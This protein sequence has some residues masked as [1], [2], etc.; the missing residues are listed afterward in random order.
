MKKIISLLI[1][2]ICMQYSKANNVE[3]NNISLVNNGD[4]GYVQFDLKWDNSWR[5]NTAQANYDGVWVF[6]KFKT[7]TGNWEQLPINSVVTGQNSL[8]PSG[9]AITQPKSYPIGSFQ[10]ISGRGF[11]VHRSA[12]NIGT[13]NLNITGMRIPLYTD[14][15]PSNIDLRAYAI[16]MVYIPPKYLQY[17]IGDG[18]GTNES[19]FAIHAA[20]TKNYVNAGGNQTVTPPSLNV[21]ANFFDDAAIEAPNTFTVGGSFVNSTTDINDGISVTGYINPYF[22]AFG[23]MW[24][25][26]Y[27][28]TQGAYRDFLNTL[29]LTQQTNR[30]AN[31]PTSTIGTGALTTSGFSRN[32]LEISIPSTAG[33][34]ATYGCDA[35]GNNVY[36]EITDGEFVACNYMNWPDIAA[37]L[38]WSGL[39]PMTEI[40]YERI[41][42]GQTGANTVP[43]LGEFAWGTTSIE[44]IAPVIANAYS[45]N[46]IITNSSSTLGNAIYGNALTGPTRNGIFATATSTRITSGSSFYG[47]MDMSGNLTEACVTIGN[48]AGRSFRRFDRYNGG[49]GLL[50]VNGNANEFGWPGTALSDNVAS[51]GSD[52]IYN[53]GT[54]NRGGDYSISSGFLKISDRSDGAVPLTRVAYQ[55][56]R[57]VVLNY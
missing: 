7:A 10:Y 53:T 16:E 33:A 49:D 51:N 54:K 52:C 32:F 38:D 46:E 27:E 17:P 55:G 4:S 56:G 47:V 37:W 19:P 22:P 9:I 24:C 14:R 30:T 29:T 11:L 2:I 40:Q 41:C 36:D 35:S 8:I 26:K 25:M 12:T 6:F 5:V 18:N 50:N 34:P 48:A 20:N 45:A 39:Y 23:N 28:I 57:G 43:I 13:G 3:I 42:R 1:L 31:A 44:T 21:D 15:L